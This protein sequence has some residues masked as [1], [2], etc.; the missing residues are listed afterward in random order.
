MEALGIQPTQLLMQ[1]IN[2]GILLAVLTKLMY[3]PIMK[4]IKDRQA[5]IDEGLRLSETMQSEREKLEQLKEK[6]IDE[7][8]AEAKQIVAEARE[9]AKAQKDKIVEEAR[10]E[11]QAEKAKAM[12]E[13]E[14]HKAALE[15]ELRVQAIELAAEMAEKAI[16]DILSGETA[17]RKALKTK[18]EALS[19]L[20]S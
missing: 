12:K 13:V 16:G 11:A 9:A 3:G 4:M 15:S 18:L 2:F 8:R 19:K 1:A 5:K 17:Q 7:G 6:K 10:I 20:K 14:A